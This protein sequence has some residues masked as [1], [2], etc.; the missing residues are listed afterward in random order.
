MKS[1]RAHQRERS[2]YMGEYHWRSVDCAKTRLDNEWEVEERERQRKLNTND[3]PEVTAGPFFIKEREVLFFFSSSFNYQSNSIVFLGLK[4]E[5][6]NKG[7]TRKKKKADRHHLFV[8]WSSYFLFFLLLYRVTVV[9]VHWSFV[10]RFS[11]FY[12]FFLTDSLPIDA[13]DYSFLRLF[14]LRFFF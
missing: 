1:A 5:I 6:K 12:R 3:D 7:R 9:Y 11:F 4:C 14:L 2:K 13:I 8:Y 10:L